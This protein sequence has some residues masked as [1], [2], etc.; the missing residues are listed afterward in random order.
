MNTRPLVC[1]A[2][3]ICMASV[4]ASDETSGHVV[5]VLKAIKDRSYGRVFEVSAHLIM[6]P[7]ED[8]TGFSIRDPTGSV[9]IRRG[10]DWP[11]ERFLAGDEVRLLCEI[12]A[13]ASQPTGAFFKNMT[14]VSRHPDREAPRNM[15]VTTGDDESVTVTR[16]PGFLTAVNLFAVIGVLVGL[17]VLVLIWNRALRTLVERRTRALLK[18]QIGHVKADLKTE[19]RTRLAVELHDTLAQNLTG[20]SMEIETANALRGTP[21]MAPHLDFASKALK[22]CRDELR[23]CLWDLRS[24][25]LE[26]P[27]MR[28]AIL[29]TLQPHVNDS[30]ITVRFPV[31][32]TKISDNTA[33]AL[34]RIVRELVVNA[35]RHGNATNIRVAGTLDRDALRCAVTDNGCGFVPESAPGLLQGHFGIQGMR[36]RIEELGGELVL[37]SAPG[38]GARATITIPVPKES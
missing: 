10:F 31:P 2:L 1:L 34:L 23:N 22:S 32:R 4:R 37:E 16:L 6:P 5:N 28:K 25:A 27:D 30:R 7:T 38:K 20:V 9:M 18:E 15:L 11:H 19:E 17:A 33:H 12:G 21:E 14:L 36:E 35:I 26:E 13:T 3:L 8:G 29:R 24:Q